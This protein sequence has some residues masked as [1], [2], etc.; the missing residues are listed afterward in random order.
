MHFNNWFLHRPLFSS[1]TC[2]RA[3]VLCFCFPTL[4]SMVTAGFQGIGEA[5]GLEGVKA[6]GWLSHE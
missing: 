4:I 2:P 3:I 5:R 6:D 1:S